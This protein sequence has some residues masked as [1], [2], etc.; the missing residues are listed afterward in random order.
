MQAGERLRRWR[1][2]SLVVESFAARGWE[3]KDAGKRKMA[4]EV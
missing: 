4:G 1:R 2:K 3:G